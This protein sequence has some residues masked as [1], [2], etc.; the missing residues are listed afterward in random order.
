MKNIS[1]VF[2]FCK[3]K[4]VKLLYL[5]EFGSHLYGTYSDSSDYDYKGIFLPSKDDLL[6]GNLPSFP[7]FSTG[8]SHSKNTKE[9]VDIDLWSLHKF[10]NLVNKGDTGA[11]DILYSYWKKDSI[12]YCDH[13]IR[14]LFENHNKLFNIHEV[15]AFI[16]F[17]VSQANRYSIKGSRLAVLNSVIDYMNSLP[18][19][20]LDFTEGKTLSFIFDDLIEKTEHGNLCCK[21][22][23]LGPNK[24]EIVAL[25]L[26]GK[27]HHTDVHLHNFMKRLFDMKNSYG[28]RSNI[29]AQ[30]SGADFK[31][32]S[33]AYRAIIE[34]KHLLEYDKIIFPLPEAEDIKKIKYGQ[35]DKDE[36]DNLISS[37]IELVENILKDKDNKENRI[38]KNWLNNFILS[39]YS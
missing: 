7:A 36:V 5:T 28:E 13:I 32:L 39:L 21:I 22:S 17:A 11:L 27:I 1:D 26:L 29:A 10:I 34:M 15:K 12:I 18:L 35:M 24:Q 2:N 19:E 33:H 8:N 23:S 16:G 25:Q 38:D 31:A 14:E 30:M 3:E 37:N 20:Y 6:L 9:D 4:N